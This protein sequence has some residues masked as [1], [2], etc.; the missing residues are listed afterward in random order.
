[1]RK[2]NFII[3]IL[4]CLFFIHNGYAQNIRQ[5]TTPQPR[6][7]TDK[8][9]SSPN[10]L[11]VR[12]KNPTDIQ[13]AY[14]DTDQ[15]VFVET[16]K[17]N[18]FRQLTDARIASVIEPMKVLKNSVS[19][20]LQIT[21][22]DGVDLRRFMQ[23][24]SADPNVLYVENV[25]LPQIYSDPNDP[26]AGSQY[27]LNLV[28]AIEAW[29]KLSDNANTPQNDIVVAIVDDGVLITHEDLAP[30]IFTNTKEIP[31]NGKD[32]DLNGY[33]DD[34]Q[35]WDA[36]GDEYI[37]GDPNP[38]PPSNQADRYTFSH[39]THCAG[40]S[41]AATNNSVGGASVSNNR[42]KILAVKATSDDTPD[43]RLI[44]HATEALMYAI[45]MRANV[46][47]MSYGSYF[48]SATVARMIREASEEYGMFFVAAAGNDN[49]N[50]PSYPAGYDY[51]MA[52]ANTTSNDVK[53][54]SSQYGPWID[55][56]A[57]GTDIIS[58]V[59]A[60]NGSLDGDYAPYTG[61]SMA[62]PMVAGAAAF[63]LT[64]DSTISP[65]QMS[66]LLKGTATDINPRNPNYQNALGSGRINMSAAMDALLSNRP[67]AAFDIL[68]DNGIINQ[69]IKFVNLS[70]ATGATYE[71]NFG[72][73]QTSTSAADT[74]VHNYSEIPELES[75][76][77]SLKVTDAEGRSNTFRRGLRMTEG[78]PSG[79]SKTLPFSTDFLADTGGFVTETVY[80][81]GGDGDDVWEWSRARGD[82]I[83]SGDST[84]WVTAAQG[85]V[86]NRSYAAILYTPTFDMTETGKEYKINFTKSMD[87]TYCNA[88]AACQMQYTVDNGGTWELLGE[89]NDGLGFGW[90]NKS[91][92]D[93]CA[94]HPI[95]FENQTGWLGIYEN[96]STAY[97]VS[98]LAGNNVR[99][100]FVYRHESA[101]Q[102]EDTDDGFMIRD[103][104]VTK[105]DPSA[106]F[107]ITSDVEYTNR[108]VRFVYNSGGA[109][110]YNW[111]F[112][113]GTTSTEQS[114]THIYTDT[115]GEFEV[116]LYI[117]GDQMMNHKDTIPILG[118]KS[119]PFE[120]ADGGDLE[121]DDLLFYSLNLAGTDL[122]KGNSTIAGKS[123]TTS[124]SNAFVLGA[125]TAGYRIPTG[126]YLYTSVFDLPASTDTESN[127][128]RFSFN[129]KHDIKDLVDGMFV[130]FSNDF[131]RS[132]RLLGG[133]T[134][135]AWHNELSSED[136]WGGEDFPIITGSTND[137]W[138]T[139]YIPLAGFEGEQIAI[140]MFF[141]AANQDSSGGIGLAMDDFR[142]VD[143]NPNVNSL[144]FDYSSDKTQVG[145]NSPVVFTNQSTADSTLIGWFFGEEDDA[146]PSVVFGEGPHE[147]EW[148]TEGQKDIV[149]FAVGTNVQ[150]QFDDA[151]LVDASITNLEDDLRSLG[152]IVYP[153]PNN[154]NM[155]YISSPEKINQIHLMKTTGQS[156]L[157]SNNMEEYKMD[158]S[159]LSPGLYIIQMEMNNGE[160]FTKKFIKK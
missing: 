18:L 1:M 46:V 67:I 19:D 138:V 143:Y 157:S 112:G 115:T 160:R 45:E 114:P 10:K 131:G 20:V 98:F 150:R 100:R 139:K 148:A 86:P 52:V 36:S 12:L 116:E 23:E 63:L 71:W 79:P 137:E 29:S 136:F 76:I 97:N 37:N 4:G 56:S 118:V 69:D 28:G 31:N 147:V 90:Y 105:E 121:S 141:V 144:S 73:S 70:Y 110:S 40:I 87:I 77:I 41:A 61:T 39:G 101:F 94:I 117:N 14:M 134:D 75:Y 142:V 82:F 34:Y 81:D 92:E 66:A 120:L 126:F 140:R 55:I 113:D 154:G 24:L 72:D 62:C 44:T 65:L 27:H 104:E 48:Y 16:E 151:I 127:T 93:A 146:T 85:G 17:R 122:A 33:V 108:P 54:P 53:A 64:Q 47:S 68:S 133:Y 7:I 155:L 83:S 57:P 59:A 88:P 8:E 145:L 132:W 109:T 124:G 103:F 152:P 102:I 21:L 111:D 149:M 51:V 15:D 99:F 74:I 60:D 91:P 22:N 119:V 156:V 95:I 84:V 6:L 130:E 2:I 125:D 153:N 5:I 80:L 106:D 123:G 42:V 58:T 25:P 35:G 49:V 129:I 135:P 96:D 50:L 26:L 43:A 78:P 9:F 11:F 32:D 159:D 3:A 107:N 13:M 89:A 30:N 128:Q 38:N 158:I